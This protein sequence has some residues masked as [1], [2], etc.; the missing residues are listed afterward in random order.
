MQF[1]FPL[2]KQN[3]IFVGYPARIHGVHENAEAGQIRRRSVGQHI[4]GS[5]CHIG[6]RMPAIRFKSEE[7]TFHGGD[8]HDVLA[9]CEVAFHEI[10]QPVAEHKGSDRVYQLE[11]DH[12]RGFNIA[13]FQSPAVDIPKIHLLKVGIQFPLRKNRFE[14]ER[15]IVFIGDLRQLRGSGNPNSRRSRLPPDRQIGPVRFR[16]QPPHAIAI[17]REK[18]L[19]RGCKDRTAVAFIF[20]KMRIKL[21]GTPDCLSR[22]VNENVEP[23][24]GFLNM[25]RKNFHARRVAEIHPK[26]LKPVAPARE[27]LLLRIAE[28]CVRGKPRKGDHPGSSAEHHERCLVPDLHAGA[29]DE[30]GLSVEIRRLKP[31]GIIELCAFRTERIVKEMEPGKFGLAD[32]AVAGRVQ[33]HD[34]VWDFRRGEHTGCREYGCF[35][36]APDAGGSPS[37]AL[38]PGV[39]GSHLLPNGLASFFERLP[40]RTGKKSGHMQKL[41]AFGFRKPRKGIGIGYQIMEY[42]DA[43][44]DIVVGIHK[45]KAYPSPG[46]TAS[47]IRKDRHR[48]LRGFR[49]RSAKCYTYLSH[50]PHRK[51]NLMKW[52]ELLKSELEFA[53]AST[54]KLV[55]LANDQMLPWKPSTGPNWMTT[56]QL[57]MHL[58]T[59]C[60]ATFKGFAT[61]DWGMPQD[62]DPSK[63]PQEEMLPPAEKMPT[64][65][66]I[67]EG[68]KLLREDK[69]T[70]LEIL[71]RCKEEDL[72]NQQ[73]PAPWD[74][75]PMSL[76][77]RLLQMIDH[78]K[79][80]KGQ[81]FYYLKLQGKPV[82]T[83]DYWG[84]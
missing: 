42:T 34:V 32:I 68:Q 79:A 33:F 71:A 21:G 25:P 54:E 77:H 17:S 63:L 36:G 14:F 58:C 41:Y 81:L 47:D 50:S 73:A 11:L 52:T 74:P 83:H 49:F 35:P 30:C 61:G 8:I 37:R 80:H 13:Q 10:Q 65:A 26:D 69:K 27:I 43:G 72:E 62:V 51:R 5:L 7:F 2:R 60:G 46:A 16:S 15:L 3:R 84:M 66:S 31:F 44:T 59:S 75:S 6:M 40:V 64:V 48:V 19:L 78:L 39:C 45:P 53:Y 12:L 18:I 24:F 22:I 56:G 57:L 38:Y 23:V 4:Q 55:S 82:N 9:A 1:L 70:A 67:A 28:R 29:G 76:G 20:K